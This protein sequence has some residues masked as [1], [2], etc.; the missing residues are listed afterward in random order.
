MSIR[1]SRQFCRSAPL[2]LGGALLSVQVSSS[3]DLDAPAYADPNVEY[4]MTTGRLTKIPVSWYWTN[5]PTGGLRLD[6]PHDV[7][8]RSTCTRDDTDA[9]RCDTG[10]LVYYLG[11][12]AEG[13][14]T[15]PFT[16]Y[17]NDDPQP[18]I[19]G[20]G[21]GRGSF[22]DPPAQAFSTTY[23]VTVFSQM[24]ATSRTTADYSLDGGQTWT[25]LSPASMEVG[26]TLVGVGRF[27]ATDRLDIETTS[28][29]VGAE[30][31]EML[32]F[33]PGYPARDYQIVS[34]QVSALDHDP[35]IAALADRITLRNYVLIGKV[36]RSTTAAAF[37]GTEIWVDLDRAPHPAAVDVSNSACDGVCGATFTPGRY[38]VSVFAA[39]DA[40]V[41]H[42]ELNDTASWHLSGKMPVL[43]KDGC[44]NDVRD[45]WGDSTWYR[46]APN[47]MVMTMLIERRSCS[48]SLPGQAMNC[49]WPVIQSRGIP[50]G[51]FG[52]DTG[53]GWNR[54]AL[55]LDVEASGVYRVRTQDLRQGISHFEKW[56]YQRNPVAT[57]LKVASY[58]AYYS[59]NSFNEGKYRNLAN[60]LGT[61]GA[62][63]SAENRVQEHPDQ[64]PWQWEA[65]V[66]ALQEVSAAGYSAIVQDELHARSSLRW[67]FAQGR[68]EDWWGSSITEGPGMSPVYVNSHFWPSVSS[69]SMHFSPEAKKA[70]ECSD[71]HG[72]AEYAECHLGENDMGDGDIYNYGTPIKVGVRR[73]GLGENRPI[74]VLNVHLESSEGAADFA[75]RVGELHSIIETLDALLQAD[76]QAF[77]R[78]APTD[79]DRSHPFYYQNRAI[80]IGD[81][82]VRAH[83]CGEHYWMLRQLRAHFGYAVDVSL[84]AVDLSGGL[85]FGAHTRDL[86]Y[87]G[88]D[89][90]R[91]YQSIWGDDPRSPPAWQPWRDVPDHS[92]SSA[93]P[94]WASDWRDKTSGEDKVGER[95]SMIVLVGRG[96][97]YDD[98]VLSYGVMSD[99]NRSSPM[100]SDARGVEMWR[101]DDCDDQGSV[102]NDARGYAPSYSLGC[103]DQAGGG[104]RPGAPALHSDHRPLGVRLRVWSR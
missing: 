46:G 35:R 56:R 23:S 49:L 83:E 58:N 98:P 94:W 32:L 74:T 4:E 59:V 43:S 80:I 16:Y 10:L 79:P 1:A 68:G 89:I 37:R 104:V 42:F 51:A 67:Q 36:T 99:R 92:A 34:S 77:N 72:R 20:T 70:A 100:Q 52:A 24:R 47:E 19:H 48:R 71:D 97:A 84:A 25:R 73:P 91:G 30:E 14:C 12:R 75:P 9:G 22:V 2:L 81:W 61:G 53:A 26:G 90:P 78:A 6:G 3:G 96:W 18:G 21:S 41:G 93:F 103:D 85:S 45:G 31:T 38:L 13:R 5:R 64:T 39:T 28:Q 17:N 102:A 62:I 8:F 95:L 88:D 54:F 29:G 69:G 27:P 55:E 87:D 60:L 7:M 44:P 40:P 63:I 101:P 33:S 66:L 86:G 65:D 15:R 57:E 11:C 82:N 76:P 50:R